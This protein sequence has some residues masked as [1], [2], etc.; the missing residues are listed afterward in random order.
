VI[1]SESSPFT[2]PNWHDGVRIGPVDETSVT[3]FIPRSKRDDRVYQGTDTVMPVRVSERARLRVDHV[4]RVALDERRW[5]GLKRVARLEVRPALIEDLDAVVAAIGDPQAARESNTSACGVRNSPC[6]TPIPPHDFMN[7][8][9]GEKLA[10]ARRRPAR[11]ALGDRVRGRHA[12]CVVSVGH[13]DAA[14][15]TDQP[16]VRLG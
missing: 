8:P 1:D 4:D 3:G 15:R 6:F 14:V 16:L 5:D 9:S 11:D 13:V 2:H 10:D 7:F 12:L